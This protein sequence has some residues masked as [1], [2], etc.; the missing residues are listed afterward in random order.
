MRAGNAEQAAANPVHDGFGG[1]RISFALGIRF[2]WD[3][4]QRLVGGAAAE[5]EARDRENAAH[6]RN[7]LKN[8]LDLLADAPGVFERGPGRRL[9]RDDEISLVFVG[10]EAFGHALENQVGKAQSREEQH[11]R[12]QPETQEETQGPPVPFCY[13]VDDFVHLPEE[14]V[15]FAMLAAQQDGRERGREGQRVESGNRNRECDGQRELAKQNAGRA[16]KEGHRHEYRHQHQRG[17]DDRSRHFSHGEGCRLVGILLAFLDVA[18]NVFDHHDGVIH[19]QSG[20]QRDTEKSERV[21]GKSQQLDESKSSDQRNR[22]GHR[23]N[24]GA[25]PVLREI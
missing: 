13:A 11:R 21:D 12:D 2:Q 5:T 16:G 20:G 23:G 18:F 10:H 1:V 8:V 17:G 22:N 6:F 4:D 19:H 25:A 15:L 7:V 3:E 24:D 9:H 14:P